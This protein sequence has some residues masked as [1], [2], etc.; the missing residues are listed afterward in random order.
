M[1]HFER[2]KIFCRF[3]TTELVFTLLNFTPPLRVGVL[4]ISQKKMGS[5]NGTLNLI[6]RCD[7][8]D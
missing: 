5:N 1:G 7:S 6:T 2:I 8:I 4:L 3:Y